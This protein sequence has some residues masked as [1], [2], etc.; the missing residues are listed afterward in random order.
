VG[1][2]NKVWNSFVTALRKL[3]H[4]WRKCVRCVADFVE[5]YTQVIKGLLERIIFVFHLLTL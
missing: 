2:R 5:K 4:L 1:E 3:V